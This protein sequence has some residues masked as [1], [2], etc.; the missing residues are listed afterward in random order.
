MPFIEPNTARDQLAG[1]FCIS[2]SP[3]RNNWYLSRPYLPC[4]NSSS[5]FLPP[6]LY[7]N[8]FCSKFDCYHEAAPRYHWYSSSGIINTFNGLLIFYAAAFINNSQQQHLSK[9]QSPRGDKNQLIKIIL[10]THWLSDWL[11]EWIFLIKFLFPDDST[12]LYSVYSEFE[13]TEIMFHVSTLL[14]YTPNNR[15]VNYFN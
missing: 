12:G 7:S 15:L 3:H 11:T 1:I 9:P 6:V 13:G 10:W 8:Y 14:P 4:Q 2:I 5:T